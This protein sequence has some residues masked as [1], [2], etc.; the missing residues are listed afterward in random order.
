MTSMGI[1]RLTVAKLLNH[2]ERGVTAVYD[3]YAY[4]REKQEAV[5]AWARR[6]EH[7]VAGERRAIG[8]R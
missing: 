4:D 5:E 6:L 2:T 8:F 1:A 3:R 7:I